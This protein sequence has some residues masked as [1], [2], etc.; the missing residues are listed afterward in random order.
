MVYY[1]YYKVKDIKSMKSLKPKLTAENLINKMKSK[2]IGFEYMSEQDAIEYL[3]SRNNYFRIASYRKNYDKHLFGEHAGQYI[4]LDFAYLAELATIDMHL[5]FLII[6][7]CLDIEHALKVKLLSDVSQN[8]DED[9]YNIVASFL[10][11]YSWITEDIYRK[12]SSSY[13]GDIINKFFYFETHKSSSG[14]IVFD[15]IDIHCPVWA[16]MEIIAFGEFIKFYDFYYE[17]YHTK[18]NYTGALNSVKSLRN[19][20]AHNNCII[21][22]L[23]KGATK[24]SPK[25]SKFISKIPSISK[26]ERKEKLSIRPLYEFVSLL[27]LYDRVAFDTVKIHRFNEVKELVNTRMIK[28]YEYFSNQQIVKASYS[29]VKKV[30]DFLC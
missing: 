17:T 22:N 12:K 24:P 21:H 2:G 4:N 3:D 8:D 20:C 18:E 16:F 13:V 11:K 25:I 14:K 10:A 30:V 29:F 23:R 19:A 26:S 1:A 6:K 28:H 7:M 9:G 27:F 15:S 5:R